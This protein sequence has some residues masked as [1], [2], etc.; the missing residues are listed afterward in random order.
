MV[1]STRSGEDTGKL[2][3]CQ[4][5]APQ[6]N[7]ND[8]YAVDDRDASTLLHT[9]DHG[10]C[11]PDPTVT[12]VETNTENSKRSDSLVHFG[13]EAEVFEYRIAADLIQGH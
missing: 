10:G 7:G 5:R 2:S 6:G 4:G 1:W 11:Q 13:L 12:N 8:E 9:D 3:H